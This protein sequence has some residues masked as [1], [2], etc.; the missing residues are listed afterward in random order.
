MKDIPRCGME[1]S[2][3]V[4]GLDVEVSCCVV[5][6]P[7]AWGEEDG[8]AICCSFCISIKT[9]AGEGIVTLKAI[10]CTRKEK[11]HA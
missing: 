8:W 7:S 6:R 5:L 1:G 2:V 11:C 4:I 3:V 9:V 10:C